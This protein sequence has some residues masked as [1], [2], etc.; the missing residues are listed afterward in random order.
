MKILRRS[1]WLARLAGYTALTVGMAGTAGGSARPTPRSHGRKRCYR[2]RQTRV[3]TLLRSSAE[4][5]LPGLMW[6]LDNTPHVDTY[7]RKAQ[8]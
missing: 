4:T 6:D 3:N 7:T 8:S 5:R 1:R 2:W